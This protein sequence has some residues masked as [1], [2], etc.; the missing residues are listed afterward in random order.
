MTSRE[1]LRQLRK[2]LCFNT[3][4]EHHENLYHYEIIEK[5]LEALEIIKRKR[6]DTTIFKY[7]NKKYV[8]SQALEQYN[9]LTDYYKITQEEY[10]I[11]REVL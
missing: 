8:P 6:I 10:D 7:L 5:D 11:L 2:H 1:A 9:N 3:E 4:Q